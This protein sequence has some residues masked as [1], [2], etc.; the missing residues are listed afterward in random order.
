MNTSSNAESPGARTLFA[1]RSITNVVP[2]TAFVVAV[3]FIPL[4]TPFAW[5]VAATLLNRLL[6]TA[7]CLTTNLEN[8]QYLY[9]LYFLS[10]F[11]HTYS[12]VSLSPSNA[13]TMGTLTLTPSSIIIMGLILNML[14]FEFIILLRLTDEEIT[15]CARLIFVPHFFNL[16]SR[17]RGFR[18]PAHP[19]DQHLESVSAKN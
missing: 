8:L 4:P 2:M 10:A 6:V 17:I 14:S 3:A 19:P 11:F 12:V 15:E 5:R 7:S 18:S 9:V 1:H 13:L 16:Q